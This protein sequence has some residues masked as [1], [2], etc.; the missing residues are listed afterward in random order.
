MFGLKEQMGNSVSIQAIW[1]IFGD[2]LTN[3]ET[4]KWNEDKMIS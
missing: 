3:I 4:Y 2:L 1:F